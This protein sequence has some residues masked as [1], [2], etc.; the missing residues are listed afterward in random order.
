MMLAKINKKNIKGFTLLELLVV[1]VF[2][3]MI[4]LG[5]YQGYFI[6]KKLI[7]HYHQMIR[8]Q[9]NIRLITHEM[10]KISSVAGQLGC[11]HT[12]LPL[13]LHWSKSIAVK[14]DE[15]LYL[16]NQKLVGLNFLTPSDLNVKKMLPH[17]VYSRLNKN[18]AI[19]YTLHAHGDNKIKQAEFYP[20]YADCQDVF[21]LS[22]Q[23]NP[24]DY[25]EQMPAMHKVGNLEFNLYFVA[26]SKRKNNQD[27]PIHSLYRYNSY[28]G[29]QEIVEGVECIDFDSSITAIKVLITS[30]EG[31]LPL[32]QWLT[33]S[34]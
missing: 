9:N 18:S 26:N 28:L 31:K 13:Y 32:K 17:P 10:V 27:V 11:A 6:I 2:S 25:F 23:E 8:L 15:F 24:L 7:G 33:I 20:V 29:S 21:V 3:S 14:A 16:D 19:I 4:L 22:P 30:V 1:M 34:L 5:I 12:K